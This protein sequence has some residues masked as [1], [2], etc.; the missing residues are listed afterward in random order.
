MASLQ[1]KWTF[2]SFENMEAFLNAIDV[3]E[4]VK[5]KAMVLKPDVAISQN[6]DTWTFTTTLGDKSTDTVFKLDQEFD[7]Q[8]LMGKI[9]KSKISLEGDKLVETQSGEGETITV[10]REVVGD[11]MLSTLSAKGVTTVVRFQRA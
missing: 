8:N 4:D 1:G 6:G 10:T 7:H 3:P 2:K 11:E 9:I 5:Q